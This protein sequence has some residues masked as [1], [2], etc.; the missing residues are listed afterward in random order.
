M[1]ESGDPL[2]AWYRDQWF[3]WY[4][5]KTFTLPFTGPAVQAHATHTL[6]L[7]P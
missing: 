1:G 7:L 3:Y 5:G 4:N 2:S 6:R